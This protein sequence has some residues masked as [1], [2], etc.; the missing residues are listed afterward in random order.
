MLGVVPGSSMGVVTAK[1]KSRCSWNCVENVEDTIETY[2]EDGMP[3][4]FPTA[5][6]DNT[7]GMLEFV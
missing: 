4:P 1:K 3:L 2:I 5:G 7:N 6:E